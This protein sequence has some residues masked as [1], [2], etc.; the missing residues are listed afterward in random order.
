M[1]SLHPLSLS[2]V[3]ACGNLVKRNQEV[4]GAWKAWFME[5][6]AQVA[7]RRRDAGADRQ[8]PGQES[9]KVKIEPGKLTYV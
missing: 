7:E 5:S 3:L 1:L 4:K 8:Y 6:T 9:Y 2:C